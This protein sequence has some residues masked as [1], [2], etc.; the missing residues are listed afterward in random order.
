MPSRDRSGCLQ[1]NE[2]SPQSV[3][4]FLV[5][6]LQCEAPQSSYSSLSD[7]HHPP[8]FP[9][10][11]SSQCRRPVALVL[12]TRECSLAGVSAQ[13]LY[14]CTQSRSCRCWPARTDPAAHAQN[15]RAHHRRLGSMGLTRTGILHS[16]VWRWRIVTKATRGYQLMISCR[17]RRV[18]EIFGDIR[19][20]TLAS[21]SRTYARYRS[22][23]FSH[24]YRF[25][26]LRSRS[27]IAIVVV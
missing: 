17:S 18:L 25:G 19:R 20:L 24:F 22:I 21:L 7:H 6:T 13:Q 16:Q 8:P 14:R 10:R 4:L 1:A 15:P 3:R 27:Y 2:F 23:P 5:S 11:P 12:R 26:Y 9:S